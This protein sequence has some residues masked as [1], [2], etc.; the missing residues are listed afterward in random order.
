MTYTTRVKYTHYGAMFREKKNSE[1]NGNLY[2]HKQVII[3]DHSRSKCEKCTMFKLV[4]KIKQ[5]QGVNL[6]DYT[7][8]NWL[9][10]AIQL[11][12]YNSITIALMYS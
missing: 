5:Q 10:Q 2:I 11:A 12:F 3:R 7:M 1:V 6:C 9:G 8:N 4:C